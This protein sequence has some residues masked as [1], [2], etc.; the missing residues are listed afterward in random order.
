MYPHM[1][2]R[3]L[4]TGV[5]LGGLG[6]AIRLIDLIQTPL[7]E[8]KQWAVTATTTGGGRGAQFRA[9]I[10]S[11]GA[12]IHTSQGPRRARGGPNLIDEEESDDEWDVAEL[13]DLGWARIPPCELAPED[14]LEGGLDLGYSQD[15]TVMGLRLRYRGH[16]N[17]AV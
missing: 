12:D 2:G 16:A 11:L 10:H 4:H 17:A 3:R 6:H 7:M 8:G 5:S 15:M 13:A 1:N 14:T 9:V